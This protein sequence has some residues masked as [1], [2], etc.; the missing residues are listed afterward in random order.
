M[1]D[2][3]IQHMSEE[4]VSLR[5]ER[6]KLSRRVLALEFELA[7]ARDVIKQRDAAIAQWTQA[8]FVL[9]PRATPHPTHP[10]AS[11]GQPAASPGDWEGEPWMPKLPV[12]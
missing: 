8:G 9:S 5:A 1:T 7:Q 11:E 2:A 6:E 3:R 4:L 10:S 12:Q